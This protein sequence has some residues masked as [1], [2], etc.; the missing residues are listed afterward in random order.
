MLTSIISL[1]AAATYGVGDFFGALGGR[2]SHPI[3]VSFIGHIFY[4]ITAFVGLLIFQG[5]WSHDATLTGVLTG[6]SEALGFLVFYYAL[7]LG[8]VALVA[9]LVS[10][11][12]ALVPVLWGLATGDHLSNLGWLGLVLGLVAVLAL[13]F[14]KPDQDDES[15]KTGRRVLVFAIIGGV[16]WGF[17]TVALSFAPKD[18][19]MVPVLIA[20]LTAFLLLL[21]IVGLFTKTVVGSYQ[22]GA[23]TPSMVSGILFGAANL[24]IITA[25]RYGQL[26]LVGMLTALYPLATVLLARIFMR[27]QITALQWFGILSAVS[28][29]VLLS[30]G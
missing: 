29:A 24:L 22:R 27:E 20:G 21:I 25:L 11:I 18:S 7:T 30:Q 4:A 3:F 12:Y 8:R 2:R 19:G 9:P 15:G 26:S 23:F 13:S 17:S 14:E 10:V 28:A 6:A 16:M 5:T 1:L